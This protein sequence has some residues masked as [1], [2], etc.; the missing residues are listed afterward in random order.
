[1]GQST[2]IDNFRGE[3]PCMGE[4]R[5]FGILFGRIILIEAVEGVGLQIAPNLF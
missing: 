2:A 4:I 3:I 5:G 1:M